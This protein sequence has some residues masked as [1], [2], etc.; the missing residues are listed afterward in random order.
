[1]EDLRA[2]IERKV[3]DK[4]TADALK[5]WYNV[6]CKRPLFLQGYY[7]TFNRE[8]VTLVDTRG[9]GLDAVTENEIVFDGE[10]Y[11][12]DCII[13]ASGFEVAAP[14]DRAGGLELK[15]RNG[16]TLKDRWDEEMLTLHGMLVNGFPNMLFI[17]GVRHAAFSWNVTYNLQ[18]QA[19][20]FASVLKHCV[21]SGAKTFEVTQSAER[22]WLEE[23][24]AKSAVDMQ[25]LADCTPGYIN[26][27][28]ADID[29]GI[30][31]QGYGPGVLA[32]AEQLASW[33]KNR[34]E[35]DLEL[36]K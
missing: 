12:V 5:P 20:H 3:K 8:N 26:N 23:L 21:D 31:S 2:E 6:F 11:P 14:L 33:R 13:F 17:G 19:E 10:K 29:T 35:S 18:L 30:A 22:D 9:H 25:F 7:D 16:I 4:K 1:M 15:G 32:Y 27:E 34:M 28:G 24:N 36:T